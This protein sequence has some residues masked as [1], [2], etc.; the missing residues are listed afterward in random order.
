MSISILDCEKWITFIAA[1][2]DIGKAHPQFQAMVPD[3]KISIAKQGI[4]FSQLSLGHEKVP[5]GTVTSKIMLNELKTV[6]NEGKVDPGFLQLISFA[7]GS[8]HG[9]I[10]SSIDV[11][12]VSP[13]VLGGVEWAALRK[14]MIK[15]VIET[16]GLDISIW[17]RLSVNNANSFFVFIAGLISVSDWIGSD[18][19]N[20]P[21]ERVASS[22]REY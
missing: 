6:L 4:H 3:L 13:S 21:Y 15:C 20:F 9:T 5:H 14:E 19:E 11:M 7:A 16:I 17:P 18:I 1:C 10:P 22:F 12:S 2:H 8:H